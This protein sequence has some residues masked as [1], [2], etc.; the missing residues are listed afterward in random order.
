MSLSISGSCPP[1]LLLLEAAASAGG[2]GVASGC[3]GI[4]WPS[5]PYFA[6]SSGLQGRGLFRSS[7]TH[8]SIQAS[9]GVAYGFSLSLALAAAFGILLP[10]VVVAAARR[11][12]WQGSAVRLFT[13]TAGLIGLVLFAFAG[14]LTW[15]V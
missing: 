3:P 1:V 15:L 2:V 5:S 6:M 13:L 7:C 14:V 11:A 10:L 12:A 4:F 9:R 8:S